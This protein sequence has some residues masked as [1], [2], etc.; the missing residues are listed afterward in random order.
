M[1]WVIVAGGTGGHLIPGIALAEEL[2]QSGEEVLFIS[3]KR[4]IERKILENRPFPVKELEVEGIV[5]RP[6]KDKTRALFK[7]VKATF[8]AYN[9]LKKYA[10]SAVLAEGG[11]VS[12]P[13]VLSAKLLGIKSALH[14]QNLLPGRAN[15]LLARL[16]DRVF[17]SFPESAVFFPANKT[18]FSGNPVRKELFLSRK[19][20]HEGPGLLILGGSLGARFLNDLVLKIIDRLF[21][22]SPSL[23]LIHQTGLEEYEKVKSQYEKWPLW[24]RHKE[25]IKIFPFI[26]DMGWAYQQADLVIAR[27]GASTLS[28][29]IA[30]KKPAIL[31]PFPYAADKHQDKNAEVLAK[32]GVA[33]VFKQEEISPEIFLERVLDLLRNNSL[34]QQMSSAYEG[35]NIAKPERII[36]DEMKKI[37]QEGRRHA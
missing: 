4:P 8:S 7:L 32:A 23:F 9:L 25:R 36:I 31:I 28:E 34:L 35:F 11:Y 27:A 33:L 30:L 6:L 14:E 20:E 12:V 10:P 5:G 13:V 22:E 19:R 18:I 21:S 24:E 2:M 26:E 16:V 1:R 29:L 37:L 15:R 3:G 17:I